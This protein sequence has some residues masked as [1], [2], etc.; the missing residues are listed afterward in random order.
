M[1]FNFRLLK[2]ISRRKIISRSLDNL[3]TIV[4]N[5]VEEEDVWYDEEK[6][7]RVSIFLNHYFVIIIFNRRISLRI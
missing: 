7:F 3:D 6:L 2:M 4:A 1:I 5:N